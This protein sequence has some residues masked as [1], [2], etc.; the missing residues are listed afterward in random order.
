VDSV[1]ESPKKERRSGE[2]PLTVAEVIADWPIA[3]TD[4]LS[5]CD[6]SIVT[7]DL[8]GRITHCNPAAE[9][10]YGYGGEELTGRPLSIFQPQ[11][12]DALLDIVFQTGSFQGDVRLQARSGKTIDSFVS[13]TLLHDLQARP[14]AILQV[15]CNLSGRNL[16][17]PRLP[18]R[19]VQIEPGEPTTGSR[20][21]VVERNIAGAPFIVASLLMHRF[22]GLVDRVASHTETVLI[23]G[24]TGTGKELIARTIHQSSFRASRQ[25]VEINCA[26]LPEH[27]V[28]SELFGY[29]KGAFRGADS[30]KAGLFELADKGTLFLDEIGELPLH[31]QVKLLRVLDGSSYYRLGGHRHVKVDVRVVAATNQDLDTAVKE[32]RSRRDLFHRLTQFHLRVPPLR[33]RPEDIAVLAR[34]F[35]KVK[36]SEKRFLEK[37]VRVLQSHK[38]PGN[39]RELRNVVTKLAVDSAT[40]QISAEE[41]RGEISHEEAQQASPGSEAV[42]VPG[43]LGMMEEQM[44]VKALERTHGHRA[45][46]AEQLGISRRTLS[47]KLR[48]YQINAPGRAKNTS[49]GAIG[50]EQQKSYRAKVQLPVRLKTAAGE[51]LELTAVNLS[52]RGMGVEGLARSAQCDGLVDVS[53]QLPDEEIAVLAKAR[54]V[55]AESEGRAGIKFISMEPDTLAKL[56]H[57]ANRKMRDEGWELAQ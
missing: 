57:W 4:I 19:R 45:M 41:V 54:V 46:A 43:D 11:Q 20:P 14:C 39:I 51:E 53:F 47:R 34:H 8:Q 15:S 33:E 3:P 21:V 13:L 30:A 40:N 28:E 16:S 17:Q 2:D 44:I 42:A 35:L 29:E 5:Q 36:T 55:W 18:D 49:L 25:F 32:G 27:L 1:D 7:A 9:E 52:S 38:W 26:A 10:M 6:F 24:E 56:Q 12:G 22:V 48:E 23:T 50:W 37:A 31:M